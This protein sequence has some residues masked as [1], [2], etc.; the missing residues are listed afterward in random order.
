MNF[1]Y[2]KNRPV[3]LLAP[4]AFVTIN[5]NIDLPVCRDCGASSLI[6]DLITRLNVNLSLESN[7][8]TASF[9]LA[10]PKHN[11]SQVYENGKLNIPLMSEVQI[12]IKGRF[13][14]DS[15]QPQYYLVFWGLITSIEKS[16]SDGFYSMH[17]SCEDMLKWWDISKIITSDSALNSLNVGSPFR[18]LSNVYSNLT[19]PEIIYALSLAMF[20][21]LV[22][23]DAPLIGNTDTV[24]KIVATNAKS[25]AT[26]MEY[27]RNRFGS[28]TD[29]SMKILGLDNRRKSAIKNAIEKN[30][31][32]N[33]VIFKTKT[34]TPISLSG[35]TFGSPSES[36]PL[37]AEISGGQDPFNLGIRSPLEVA[38]EV[39]NRINFEFFMDTG[40][41]ITF[42]P[43]YY[44]L[45]TKSL[46]EYKISSL[47]LLSYSITHNLDNIYTRVD[48]EGAFMHDSNSVKKPSI[49][50]IDTEKAKTYGI[51][52]N[53]V[54]YNYVRDVQNLFYLAVS[55]LNRLNTKEYTANIEIA[56]RPELKLG[57][58]I[59][60]EEED[61]YCYV[62]TISHDFS[63]GQSFTTTLGVDTLRRKVSTSERYLVFSENKDQKKTA[64]VS[65]IQN[66]LG[67]DTS[68]I[69]ALF[70]QYKNQKGLVQN[71]F[72]EYLA[73]N[74]Q[75]LDNFIKFVRDKQ[76]KEN[77]PELNTAQSTL[78]RVDSIIDTANL[79]VSTI[80]S[81]KKPKN[82]SDPYF[83]ISDSNGYDLVPGFAY[84]YNITSIDI[85]AKVEA[86]ILE[87]SA[88]SQNAQ[89]I[90]TNSI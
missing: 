43:P 50:Y 88:V 59:Y 39:K 73:K 16:Y 15:G 5:Q 25:Y 26:A 48:I 27:W 44:N 49:F 17:V 75:D 84:G 47:D 64:I 82:L 55:E 71:T 67:S 61:V 52:Q 28:I 72:R 63:F 87:N 30:K 13:L 23:V 77:K 80:I 2:Q 20:K 24:R 12:F 53:K 79:N 7:P 70:I 46:N 1:Q 56:G 37:Y 34:F 51:K 18:A 41:I 3:L 35:G 57:I 36:L 85:E 9:D 58:P 42:K 76:N 21:D 8:G 4:D 90:S 62:R 68:S 38:N 86:I 74:S 14:D 66:V 31:V 78:S 6:V 54:S 11:S 33:E 40:G 45:N 22:G 65:Q 29:Q 81:D 69:E 60:L 19:G 83:T 10:V 32:D 89:N